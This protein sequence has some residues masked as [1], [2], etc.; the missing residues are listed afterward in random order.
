MESMCCADGEVAP[1]ALDCLP[2]D[3]Y[4]RKKILILFDYW[5]FESLCYSKGGLGFLFFVL[6]VPHSLQDL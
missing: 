2:V 4:M 1:S 5:T 6:V 3:C